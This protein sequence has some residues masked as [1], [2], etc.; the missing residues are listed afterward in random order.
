MTILSFVNIFLS[1]MFLALY[2]IVQEGLWGVCGFHFAWNLALTNIYG[3]EISGYPSM[4]SLLKFKVDGPEFITGGGF[5]P[6]AGILVTIFLCAG[7][8][9]LS[10]RIFKSKTSRI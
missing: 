4:K 1:G 7:I 10:T 2:A 9:I 8:V 5:G 3:F 6:E